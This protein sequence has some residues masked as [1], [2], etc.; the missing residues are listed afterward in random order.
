M[1]FEYQTDGAAIYLQ[2]SEQKPIWHVLHPMTSQLL[3]G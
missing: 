2:P 1:P 3:C